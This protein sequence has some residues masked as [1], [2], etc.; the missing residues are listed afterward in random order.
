MPAIVRAHSSSTLY[1]FSMYISC[2]EFSQ[3]RKNVPSNLRADINDLNFL[4]TIKK[5]AQSLLEDKNKLS[6]LCQ[7]TYCFRDSLHEHTAVC[8]D[9]YSINQLL[10]KLTVCFQIDIKRARFLENL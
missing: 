3:R 8:V 2:C 5:N 10:Q 4:A 1:I 6:S 7:S 9:I